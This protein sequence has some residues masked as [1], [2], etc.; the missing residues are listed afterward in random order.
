MKYVLLIHWTCE[1][2]KLRIKKVLD[3]YSLLMITSQSIL[4]VFRRKTITDKQ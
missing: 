3:I 4:G 1:I 2:T